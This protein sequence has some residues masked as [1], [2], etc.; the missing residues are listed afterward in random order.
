MINRTD[1]PEGTTWTEDQ[2]DAISIHGHDMLVA[3]AAGSGKTAVLV[4]RIIRRIS[5]EQEPV[6]VDRLLVATFTN[7]AAAEMRHRISE[8]LE[9]ELERSPDSGHL[10]KQLALIGRASITTLHSFCLDVIRTHYQQVGLD[11][12]FRIANETESDLMRQ[13]LIEELFE[14]QYGEAAEDS[15][16][17][18]LAEWFSGEKS[19]DALYRLVQ[20][21]YD[22]AR[23]HPW[24]L[25]WLQEA[26]NQFDRNP[27]TPNPWIPDLLVSVRLELDGIVLLLQDATELA[28][29]PGGP[30][31]YLLNLQE[32]M[33]TV[34]YL[35]QVAEYS[36][37]HLYDSFQGASFGKL[38]PCKGA[39][40]D[41]LLQEQVKELRNKAK[42]QLSGLAEEL[43]SRTPQE[44]DKEL[45]ILAPLMH[46]LVE[47]VMEFS[48]R[49][50]HAKKEKGLVDFSDLE[51][52]CL[53]LLS[54]VDPGTGKL[55][56][57]D[58][59]LG[60][61][62][63][64]VEVLLDEYQDTNRVQ[65][66]IVSF[67]SRE[68]P[69]NR[70]MVGDV[71][72]SIYRFRLAE[73]GLFLEKY[74]NYPIDDHIPGQRIDLAKNFRSRSPVVD[75]VNY[76]FKH[77]MGEE[78]GEIAY[79][80]RA[81]LVH[82]AA[83]YPAWNQLAN[84]SEAIELLMIDRTEEVELSSTAD[85]ADSE[86]SATITDD[87]FTDGLADSQ[88]G[89]NGLDLATEAREM[90][91][92]QL[93][94]RMIA[95][96]IH[97]L[98]GHTGERVFQV[99]DKASGG[100]RDATYRDVVIL[101]R[102]TGQWS[103]IMIEELRQQGIPAYAE[104]NTGYF[105]AMEVEV[106]LSLLKLID[107]P[108]QDIPLASVLR[109]PIVQLSEEQLA[110]IRIAS[111]RSSFYEAVSLYAT[112]SPLDS[113]VA[114]AAPIDALL[115]NKLALFLQN[116]QG[117]R[118][119]ARQGALADLI[120]NI[121]RA[122][123]FYDFI[124]GLP[125]GQQRQANLRALY[126]RA[127]Q[128]EATSF[129]G[130]FRFLRFVE[131][132][133]D[134]GKD[135][136][137]A[138]A[139]G[140]QEDVVRIM[141]IHKSKGLEFPVV[142]VAALSKRF[143]MRDLTE[144]FM[145]HKDLGFGP[146]FTDAAA[147]TSYP[148]LPWLAIRRKLRMEMI[149][150]EMRVLYVA[151][152]RAREKL[153]LLATVKGMDKLLYNWSK[154]IDHDQMLLPDAAVAGARSYMDW[155][156][157]A[158][159]RHPDGNVLRDYAAVSG[160]HAAY[161]DGEES[162]W[163][164]HLIRPESVAAMVQAAATVEMDESRKQA[165]LHLEPVDEGQGQYWEFQVTH[166]LA[167]TYAHQ[168]ASELPSKISVTELKRQSDHYRVL[169]RDSE[170][171]TFPEAAVPSQSSITAR[172]PRFMELKQMNAAERG[173]V[174]HSVMQYIPLDHEPSAIDVVRALDEMV[175]KELLTAEQ[176]KLLD[177]EIIVA[178]FTSSV[179]IRLLQASEVYREIPF[180]LGLS[181][182]EAYSSKELSS[183]DESETVLLQ[184]MI[185]CLFVE[186]NGLVLVDFKTDRLLDDGEAAI[187]AIKER[188]KQQIDLY[189]NAVEKIWK[190]PVTGKYIFLFDG[191]KL[192][193]L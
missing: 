92:V 88:E 135:L 61:R 144:A 72:Q 85:D 188:H 9:K 65:E 133:K 84:G 50:Q 70:F 123:G 118:N 162:L 113:E 102:A 16:F 120:W 86:A 15:H 119:E 11:P 95:A 35:K 131:R 76:I 129:R 152:T 53:Q 62:E 83:Y 157:P 140:E 115:R 143:N 153:Y 56:P 57:S 99:F 74:K 49:Y 7:A 127:R 94:A 191:A 69:G 75:G 161:L 87:P 25:Q 126:D 190:R 18:K 21:L 186:E 39:D 147:R 105:S 37:E 139:L 124:G 1:K 151:L 171:S 90:E 48:T 141:S 132:M 91:T 167:W 172:R 192:L 36:W 148:T 41:K 4:E 52:Y 182:K 138:R 19:D 110:Q 130:L 3:A 34:T 137:T 20:K 179:G 44:Y 145:V 55:Q 30:A 164:I 180:S 146:K 142:F 93:E 5:N 45:Q 163:K 27:E 80:S 169:S 114:K 31:P 154:Y 54:E 170:E 183:M 89:G 24:P 125:G 82:G 106:V 81:Q 12:G 177:P 33:D 149:A 111:P 60:Y 71:K 158:L 117:W 46:T 156:G 122:T 108:F 98:L 43:F 184:G 40:Y 165:V 42:D 187:E 173:T 32:D 66:T 175:D 150:E 58:I 51:H 67:I 59:A 23:S 121:Y 101:L 6:D 79:D 96:Q 103:P 63:R 159:M 134:S 185:D 112:E 100:Y 136:G 77:I 14:E 64:Y 181:A 155:I 22:D 28:E 38:R 174:F 17:W 29:R 166:R 26:A 73:P 160:R 128:Y 109:S 193:E 78:V 116:L 189:A 68:N 2:W 107:N 97:K 176:H 10:R 178:F 8:A 13:D 47:L 168:Q 104:L